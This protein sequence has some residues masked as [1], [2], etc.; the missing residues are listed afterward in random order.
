MF[1]GVSLAP[2]LAPSALELDRLQ[3]GVRVQGTEG[4]VGVE[5]R[6]FD[7]GR[8]PVLPF[9]EQPKARGDPCGC[10][11]RQKPDGDAGGKLAQSVNRPT[12]SA[13]RERDRPRGS[14]PAGARAEPGSGVRRTRPPSARRPRAIR[15]S[16]DA[17]ARRSP[18]AQEARPGC[19]HRVHCRSERQVRRLRQPLSYLR[20]LLF[21]FRQ[22]GARGREPAHDRAD[23][24][25]ESRRRFSVSVSVAID[26]QHRFAL[27]LWKP[28]DR[29]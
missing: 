26:E 18:G 9:V 23:R 24:D 4:L 21:Q 11:C 25:R 27:S 28:A 3:R 22:G 1:S 15:R 19:L 29:S 12:A 20:T 13:S 17:A 10:A 6:V 7:D 2:T 8:A 14:R 16:A 5:V